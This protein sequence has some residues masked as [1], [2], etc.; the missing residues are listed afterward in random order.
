MDL[1]EESNT[2]FIFPD[3][4]G[5]RQDPDFMIKDKFQPLLEE[6]GLQNI[7]FIELRDTYARILIE[8]NLPLTYVMKQ[9]GVNNIKDFVD[10]Y[11]KFIPEVKR[12][13]F[14]LI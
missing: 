2:N 12:G 9:I 4:Y 7:K 6:A 14:C 11:Q 1:K 3:E 8:Q 5:K 13:I 10:K